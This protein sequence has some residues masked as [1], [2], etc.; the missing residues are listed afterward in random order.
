MMK[1]PVCGMDVDTDKAEFMAEREGKWYYF[2]SDY[3]KTEFI[4]YP[5]G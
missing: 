1:D 4:N 5:I 2:C 3:C